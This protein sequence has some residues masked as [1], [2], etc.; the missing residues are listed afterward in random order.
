M[1]DA[2][3]QATGH[4]LWATPVP[5]MPAAMRAL[6]DDMIRAQERERRR[7]LYVAMT[8]AESWL[9][10]CAAGE[11]G[12][13]ADSWHSMVAEGMDHAGAVSHD[14]GREIGRRYSVLDWTTLPHAPAKSAPKTQTPAPQ[15]DI[16]PPHDP[17]GSGTLSP[18]EL[19]GAKVLP[20]D[21]SEGDLERS[22]A[23]GRLIHLLLEHLPSIPPDR[24]AARATQIVTLNE[25]AALAGD[26]T[27]LIGDAI[28]MIGTPSL[29]PIFAIGTLAEVD[30]TATVPERPNHRLH[31]AIDRL[32][33]TPNR[34]TAV[35]FKT[36]RL[37]PTTPDT[38]PEG[39]L[40]QMGAYLAMLRQIYPDRVIDIAILWTATAE[41][42][43]LPHAQVMAALQ[44]ATLP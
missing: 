1:L 36:N 15:F 10:I 22:L 23:R 37:V 17:Q 43:P 27:D 29:A 21:P 39:I 18:S 9:I 19:G 12:T 41:L 38:V 32:V 35:D 25:D 8:R 28:R 26:S 14:F 31:G 30:L 13:G 42:M 4:I 6:R 33:I 3:Y 11:T 2:L 24:Q 20:G 5:Q 34:I 7:L 16:L 44:R 40:R